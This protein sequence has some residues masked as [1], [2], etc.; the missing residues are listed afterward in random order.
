MTLTLACTNKRKHIINKLK[1]AI[2]TISGEDMN[3]ES[4]KLRKAKQ[5]FWGRYFGSL[6]R[7]K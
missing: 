5:F 4:N 2:T 7:M 1:K 6:I 3:C